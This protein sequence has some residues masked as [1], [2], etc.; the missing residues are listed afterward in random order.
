MNKPLKITLISLGSLVGVLVAAFVV[1]FNVVFS[2]ERLT[3]IVRQFAGDYVTCQTEVGSVDLSLFG[4]FPKVSLRLNDVSIV[5]P[6]DNAPSDTVLSVKALF[7]ELDV[8]DYLREEKVTVTGFTLRNAQANLYISADSVAN[9][10]IFAIES[11]TTAV[12]DT[13]ST[14]IL[15]Q[16]SLHNITVE[17][18]SGTFLDMTSQ[19]DA[20]LLNAHLTLNTDASLQELTGGADIDLKADEIYYSDSLNFGQILD[21][22]LR[23]ARLMYDG[24]NASVKVPRLRIADQEYLLSGDIAL[25]AHVW[26]MNLDGIDLAW[27]DER[28]TLTGVTS[29]DSAQVTMGDENLMYVT[30]D[31][32]MIDLPVTS[33]AERWT[34]DGKTTIKNLMFAMDPDGTMVDHLDLDTRFK[35]ST[36]AQFNDFT[37]TDMSTTLGSQ[38]VQ[39]NVH[40][41]M[42]DT[43]VLKADVDVLVKA[44]SLNELLA[45]IPA[46]YADALKGMTVNAKLDDS[47]ITAVCEVRGD[48]F[49][50]QKTSIKTGVHSLDYADDAALAAD[51][52]NVTLAISYPAGSRGRQFE[53]RSNIE[54]LTVKQHDDSTNLNAAIPDLKLTALIMDDIIDGKDPRLNAKFSGS[55]ITVDMDDTISVKITGANGEADIDLKS[56]KNCIKI[57]TKASLESLSAHVGNTLDGSTGALALDLKALYDEKQAEI[58]DQLSPEVV[59]TLADGK[60]DVDGI[61]YPVLLPSVDASFDKNQ[62]RL[63][64]CQLNLGNSDLGLDGVITNISSWMKEQAMLEGQLNLKSQR[65]DADQ[66][67]DLAS[68]FGVEEEAAEEGS[69]TASSAAASASAEPTVEQKSDTVAN[70]PFMVPKDVNFVVNTNVKAVT[71]NG[72]TFDNVGGQLTCRDGVLVLEEMGFTS[73][74]ARMQLTALYRSPRRNNLFASWNFHLLDI[75]IAEMIRL[76][77]DID[78]I[79]P[80]LSAFQGKAEFHLAGETS[81]FSDY[82][83]KMSS[84][85]AVASIEGKDLTVLDSET[86]QTI[87]KYLFKDCTTNKIDTMSVELAV[88]RRKMTLYPMLI[89]WDKYEAIIA[90]THTITGAMPFNYNISITKCPLVGGHLG[91]DITGNIDDI[92]NISF[93]VG[94]CKYANLY[95]PEKRNVTQEQT[96]ELKD[97]I[98]TSLKRTVK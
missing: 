19:M 96:L 13:T 52:D 51:L 17:G 68:G 35:A 91:L 76:V 86:F 38:T 36:N 10:D 3:S 63:N 73:K 26:N 64:R 90:G 98:S 94:G 40:V 89:G 31:A 66:L 57:A 47:R 59:F 2:Q 43:T 92:D 97:L 80:M 30:T 69:A 75:D 39:G 85:K 49:K 83:P 56:V 22:E 60:F 32:V 6:M 4:N 21:L 93:K 84:L 37:V 46:A 88:A 77:P 58:L 72:N 8:M 33:T 45:M 11:D 78:T 61:P 53:I 50:L 81:L 15:D 67:M 18:L 12:A 54:G 25:S 24:K 34:T 95:R 16:L 62:A 82:S 74:A 42:T 70:D 65:V 55:A 44:T 27:Q 28:P 7:A 71:T 20:R 79:V 48:Q 9:F 1:V 23:D 87:K 41:D 5:N 29:M 14:D